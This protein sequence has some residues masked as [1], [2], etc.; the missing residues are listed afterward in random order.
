MYTKTCTDGGGSYISGACPYDGP[1]IKCCI[2]NVTINGKME[3][4][5]QSLNVKTNH[6]LA[7]AQVVPMLNYVSI[8]TCT[9]LYIFILLN[10]LYKINYTMYLLNKY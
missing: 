9:K 1:N 5:C 10:N 4:V 6:S 7:I 8:M 2:K 3:I